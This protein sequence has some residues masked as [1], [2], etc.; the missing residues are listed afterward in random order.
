MALSA[1]TVNYGQLYN[2]V[3]KI[4]AALEK[5]AANEDGNVRLLAAELRLLVPAPTG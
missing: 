3:Q 5:A 4:A 1:D 2:A